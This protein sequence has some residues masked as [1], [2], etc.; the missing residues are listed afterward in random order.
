VEFRMIFRRVFFETWTF[1]T[2]CLPRYA[3]GTR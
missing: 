1:L 2:F 3:M